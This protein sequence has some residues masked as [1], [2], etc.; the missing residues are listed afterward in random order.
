VRY[1]PDDLSNQPGMLFDGHA[2]DEAMAIEEERI[3]L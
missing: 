1:S 2:F 3:V